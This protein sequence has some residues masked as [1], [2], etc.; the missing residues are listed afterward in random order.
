[1]NR[2]CA[3]FLIAVLLLFAGVANGQINDAELTA[4][5]QSGDYGTI[6]SL[7]IQ[8][9]DEPIY[10]Q[11]FRGSVASD[12]H[13]LNS[14]TKSVGATLLG[15]AVRRNQVSIDAPISTY[16][17]NY[18]WQSAPMAANADL[19]LRDILPMRSGLEWDEWSTSFVDPRNSFV[20]M[21]ES[22]D[23]YRHVLS[24]SRVAAPNTQFTYNTGSSILMSGVL[25]QATGKLPQ[26]LLAQELLNPL[27]ISSWRFEIWGGRRDFPFN[28]APL[29]VGLWLRATDMLKIGRLLLD[30]GVI[31]ER[32][33]IDRD[34]IQQ[35]F[36]LYNHAGN[37]PRFESATETYGYGYQWWYAGV[38][39][40][41]GREHP[42]WYAD[43]AGRQ[44]L[45]MFPQLDL[46]VASTAD[47]YARRG[48]GV[49]TLLR[50]Q[51]LPTM[52]L[53]IT[54]ELA[55]SYYNPATNGEG[56]NVEVLADRNEVL[57]YWYTQENGAQRF[58]VLQGPISG[59]QADLQVFTTLGGHFQNPADRPQLQ[60]AGTAT[61]RW[62]GCREAVLDYS[63]ELGSGS[64]ELTR[65]SGL[66][67]ELAPIAQ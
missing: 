8:R 45:M 34:W 65:L 50:E 47:D 59:D 25:R 24:L 57:A 40:S 6:K 53:S 21:T 11:H 7:V 23:W 48:P 33:I 49:L 52:S 42:M 43:G 60:P 67:A 61:L 27:G 18:A 4:A 51:I 10:E 41:R 5:V 17:P 22:S 16:F 39:D 1:M 37:E 66:C 58:Y 63:I 64:Y 54:P 20:Q 28:D 3:T 62:N 44:Y 55:G 35:M 32:R 36:T 14:V 9:G 29:G 31:S 2:S 19:T 30:G 26:Q 38:V 15:V 13:L 12:L 56:L 46:I